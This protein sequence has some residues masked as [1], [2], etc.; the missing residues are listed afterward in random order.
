MGSITGFLDT[1]RT[2]NPFRNEEV[3]LGDL[4]SLNGKYDFFNLS[5]I[6]E[7]MSE[8]DFVRNTSRLCKLSNDGARLA[9]YNMQN[10]RYFSDS[11]LSLQTELSEQLTKQNRAFAA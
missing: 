4:E 11:R 10:K 9:Y 5:D 8:E 7:Y 3:R 2:E 6:F 1:V